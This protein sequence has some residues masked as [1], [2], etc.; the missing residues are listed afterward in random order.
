[1]PNQSIAASPSATQTARAMAVT[2]MYATT[3]M[4]YFA[5][6]TH[7]HFFKI[8]QIHTPGFEIILNLKVISNHVYHLFRLNRS[9]RTD[10]G[11]TEYLNNRQTKFL[12]AKFQVGSF[13][14]D[15]VNYRND[16]V[17]FSTADTPLRARGAK[18]E[19]NMS[20]DP[21]I[22]GVRKQ[23]WNSSTV[24]KNHHSR[25]DLRRQLQ[26]V[27]SGLLDQTAHASS[28]SNRPEGEIA[29]YVRYLVAIT[30]QGPIGKYTKQ[31][32]LPLD[33]RG[34]PAHCVESSWP[35]WCASTSTK[36]PEDD[37]LKQRRTLFSNNWQ[38][39]FKILIDIR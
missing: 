4:Y 8:F 1:M 23:T 20:K 5:F 33:E 26:K 18:K 35:D 19:A 28:I 6:H 10:K 16:Q 29:D 27:R 39:L 3:K 11:S 15:K 2:N 30:G 13:K 14:G 17:V 21:D 25:K 34:L 36:S 31:W 37:L 38:F 7:H 9:M 32:A 22:L 12:K 24:L